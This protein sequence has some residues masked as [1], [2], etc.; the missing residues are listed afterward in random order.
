MFFELHI[1]AAMSSCARPPPTTFEWV[2]AVA[3]R[4]PACLAIVEGSQAWT[5]REFYEALPRLAGG[6]VDR[7]A[8][9]RLFQASP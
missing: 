3:L 1:I 2:E 8:L 7:I 5:D 9:R 4:E 6:K